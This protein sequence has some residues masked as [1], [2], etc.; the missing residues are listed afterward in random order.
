MSQQ[1]K[2]TPPS[3]SPDA[4]S[5]DALDNSD[6]LRIALRRSHQVVYDWS[7]KD[8]ALRW[9]DALGDTFEF[10]ASRDLNTGR[11]FHALIEDEGAAL[12]QNLARNPSPEIDTFQ[13]EYQILGEDG[14]CWVE[15]RGA[16]FFDADGRPDRIVGYLQVISERKKRE[17]RLDYLISHDELTG[18]LNRTRLRERLD[19]MI[20]QLESS[21]R[22]GAYF[23]I[24]VD[25][26]AIIN[27][28]YGFDV[29]DEVLVAISDR[30]S[31]AVSPSD[32]IGRVA[33]NKFGIIV[34]SCAAD[35]MVP[36]AQSLIDAV[37]E[38]VVDTSAGPIS[39]SI[40]VGCVL[41]PVLAEDSKQAMVRAEEALDRAKRK[42]RGSV[43]AHNSS[44]EVESIRRRNAAI[45]DSVVSA[46]NDR[47]IQLAYQ[48]IVCAR[49]FEVAQYEC[50]IRMIR[51]DGVVEPAGNFIPLAEQLGLIRLLDRRALEIAIETLQR[52]EDIHLGINVSGVTATEAL[53][54][55]GYLAH[56]EAYPNLAPRLTVEI[57]ET[58]ALRDLEQSVQF[59]HWLRELGCK[60]AI[61]D[62]GAGFT[63]FSYL[64]SLEVDCV[65]ID[66]SFVRGLA[67]K[68]DNQLFVRTLVDLARNLGIE[69]VAEFVATREEVDLLAGYGVEYLQGYYFAE[70]TMDLEA[71]LG[72]AAPPEQKQAAN[73]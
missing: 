9:D 65:K 5:A 18:H 6:Y 66:G 13:I 3:Q 52:H 33:G 45:A 55:E 14:P 49:S 68:P 56:V 50:L 4:H 48:P 11:K 30:L 19:A 59:I 22:T 20:R 23:T 46:L 37:H 41:L 31:D 42:G 71:A 1:T 7:L 61:D 2:P 21:E 51:P 73:G 38:S 8:D 54:I 40:S 69:T 43:A 47:R 70:P 64:K 26:L 16:R 63:S 12:R 32:K 72:V 24:G 28:E 35:D 34:G 25:D 15:D 53:C 57:T 67:N 60:V 58:S 27:S 62:F 29:A 36:L 39:V 17:A 10:L 44:T